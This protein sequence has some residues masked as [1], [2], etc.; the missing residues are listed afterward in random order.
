MPRASRR[1]TDAAAPAAALLSRAIPPRPGHGRHATDAP[2]DGSMSVFDTQWSVD[3][4]LARR[5][6]CRLANTAASLQARPSSPSCPT[7]CAPTAC[8]RTPAGRSCELHDV[9]RPVPAR[10]AAAACARRRAEPRRAHR[11]LRK[12]GRR[13]RRE[14]GRQRGGRRSRVRRARRRRL[15]PGDRAMG[16][17]TG[18]FAEY[19]LLDSAKRSPVPAALDWVQAGAI[20]LTFM[21]V[22]DMLVLQGRLRAGET[23]LIAGVSSGR[24]RHGTAGG[25]GD[26]RAR[27]RHL[28]QRRQARAPA[29]RGPGRR[30]VHARR[31]LRRCGA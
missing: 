9:P 16:R 10:P 13:R 28:G 8:N 3:T 7:L 17:C 21:V 14:A 19:A 15:A 30:A 26:G 29:G 4:S 24:R 6:H 27:D 22:Y 18:A 2:V 1:S 12:A 25:Q 20:P 11:R 23:L 5:Q 31:R